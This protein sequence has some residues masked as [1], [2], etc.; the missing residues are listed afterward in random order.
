MAALVR[1]LRDK[2]SPPTD[3][4]TSFAGRTVLITGASTGLGL[5]AAIK[6]A[7][8]GAA[9]LILG[10]RDVSS[11]G[12]K[13]KNTIEQRAKRRRRIST[14]L[15]TGSCVI[16]LWELDLCDFESVRR[17]AER[18]GREGGDVDAVVLNAGVSMKELKR[19]RHG[20]EETLQVNV[21]GT[22]L[23]GLLLLPV[24]KRTA[25]MEGR[26][27]RPPVL[28]IVT[29]S[30]YRH[31]RLGVEREG[32]LEAFNR[33]DG[34]NGRRQYAVSKALAMYAMR[35]LA[36]MDEY[37]GGGKHVVVMSAS[38]GFCKSE[39]RRNYTGLAAKGLGWL[40]YAIF[41]R[42][43]EE[44]ARSLVSAMCLG[45]EAHD[46]FWHSDKFLE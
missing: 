28:E 24:L 35:S 21:L 6:T 17:F 14:P 37:T 43:A 12:T 23:L 18:V 10:V 41:A 5:E 7:S 32:I 36:A 40:F 38:P 25:E 8:L 15:P 42:E 1:L 34:F 13:A 30:L 9:R 44:G 29:S 2:W 19:S 3:P 22:V 20:W 11:K 46:G 4:S 26:A 45:E 31:A 33:E 39:L 27:G 16:D